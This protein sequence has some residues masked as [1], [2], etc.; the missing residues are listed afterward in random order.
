MGSLAVKDLFSPLELSMLALGAS[1]TR[2][3]GHA[4]KDLGGDRVEGKERAG[5]HL[6]LESTG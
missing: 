6:I 4:Q 2:E 3:P 1:E 5:I